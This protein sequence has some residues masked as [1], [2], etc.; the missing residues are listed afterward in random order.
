MSLCKKY[1]WLEDEDGFKRIRVSSEI[2][3]RYQVTD[4]NF[5]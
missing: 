5:V 3:L 4:N 1:M 2:F